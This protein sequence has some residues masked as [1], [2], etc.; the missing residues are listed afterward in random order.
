MVEA[1]EELAGRRREEFLELAEPRPPDFQDFG[2]RGVVVTVLLRKLHPLGLLR[3]ERHSFELNVHVNLGLLG[4]ER[5]LV[6][7]LGFAGFF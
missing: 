4:L 1:R 5:G 2:I 3:L 6:G 7:D